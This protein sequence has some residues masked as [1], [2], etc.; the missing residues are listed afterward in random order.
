M[1]HVKTMIRDQRLLFALVA[2]AISGLLIGLLLAYDLTIE[3]TLLILGI[4]LL[5]FSAQKAVE[6]SVNIA[7]ALGVSPLMIDLLIVSLG[8]NFPELRLELLC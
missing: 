2:I 8:T 3:I 4:A 5:A 7:S 6:H 1:W